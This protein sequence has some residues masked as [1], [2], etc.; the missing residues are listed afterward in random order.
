MKDKK[1]KER[2]VAKRVPVVFNVNYIH[3]GDYIISSTRDVSADGMFLYT[4]NPPSVSEKIKL[5]FKLG[6]LTNL[7]VDA[8]VMWVNTSAADPKDHGMAVK[9]I[10]PGVRVKEA[11]LKVVNRVAVLGQ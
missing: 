5:K 2:R 9:F 6:T 3:D 4:E 11:V 1:N 8:K 7:E 10:K